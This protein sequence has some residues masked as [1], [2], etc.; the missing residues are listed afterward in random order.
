MEKKIIDTNKKDLEEI[1]EKLIQE[2]DN[3]AKI[4]AKRK[5]DTT[6]WLRYQDGLRLAITLIDER[7]NDELR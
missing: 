1:K 2:F 3:V 6:E 5:G 4:K 7:L